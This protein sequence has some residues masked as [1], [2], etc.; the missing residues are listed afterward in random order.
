MVASSHSMPPPILKAVIF[1][2]L[3]LSSVRQG[4]KAEEEDEG[5]ESY[6]RV[7]RN[8][9]DK[10]VKGAPKSRGLPIKGLDGT[11]QV[12]IHYWFGF[13]TGGCCDGLWNLV[14]FRA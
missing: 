4:K 7:P 13:N 11:M 5:L 6:E 14:L 1:V 2:C 9:K 12:C 8:Q 10:D 3:S